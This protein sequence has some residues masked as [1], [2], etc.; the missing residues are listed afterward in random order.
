MNLNINKYV[1]TCDY[2]IDEIK[3][4]LQSNT[5]NRPRLL[6]VITGKRFIGKVHDD[7]FS[8][9]ES[10]PIGVMCVLNGTFAGVGNKSTVVE[11]EAKI[12]KSFL[13]LYGLWVIVL[14]LAA[15][16]FGF[17]ND[18]SFSLNLLLVFLAGAIGFRI[19]IHVV[20][21]KSRK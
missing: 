17:I 8:L 19:F 10:S 5:L 16:L 12:Q 13:I 11:V 14:V 2:N 7:G 20:Y 1:L 15:V 6:R 18:Q 9:I 4:R 3:E 21:I